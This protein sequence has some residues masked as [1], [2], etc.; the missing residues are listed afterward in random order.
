MYKLKIFDSKKKLKNFIKENKLKD[1]TKRKFKFYF[2][3]QLKT[4]YFLSFKYNKHEN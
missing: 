1:Y 3:D 2:M 4:N